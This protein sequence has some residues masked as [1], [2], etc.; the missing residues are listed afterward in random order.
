MGGTPRIQPADMMQLM[1]DMDLAITFLV[2]EVEVVKVVN[3]DVVVE[4][5]VPVETRI[6]E[7]KYVPV[8]VNDV[9]GLAGAGKNSNESTAGHTESNVSQLSS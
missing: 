8:P 9:E 2:K 7:I 6:R 1:S 4:K 5:A 3:Q